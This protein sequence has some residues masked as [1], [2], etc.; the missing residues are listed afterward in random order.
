MCIS[1]LNHYPSIQWFPLV[2]VQYLKN[3]SS[4]A[5]KFCLYCRFCCRG[6]Y[7]DIFILGTLIASLS[8]YLTRIYQLAMLFCATPVEPI[9]IILLFAMSKL[10]NPILSLQHNDVFSSTT[11]CQTGPGGAASVSFVSR[12]P[13]QDDIGPKLKPGPGTESSPSL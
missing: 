11:R 1:S 10:R 13:R 3:A 4:V 5:S 7:T 8:I 2:N 6:S 9:Y 12:A